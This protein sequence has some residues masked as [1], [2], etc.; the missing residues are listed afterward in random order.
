MGNWTPTKAF[1]ASV[2]GLPSLSKATFF[3][4]FFPVLAATLN[5]PLFI[6]DT[7]VSN[8]KGILEDVGV[9]KQMGFVPNNFF[10]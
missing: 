5:F 4:I 8:M 6:I 7:E 2:V 3:G 10:F 1:F 9:P